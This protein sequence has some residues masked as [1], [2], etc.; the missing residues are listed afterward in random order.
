MTAAGHGRSDKPQGPYTIE[1]FADDLAICSTASAGAPHRLWRV[2]GRQCRHCLCRGL[3]RTR[4]R[5]GLFDTTCWY[6]ADAPAQ[7]AERAQKAID[8]GMKALVGFQKT[9][10][11]SDGFRDQHPDI[12]DRA[13]DVFWPMTCA[14]TRKPAACWARRT[15]AR[16]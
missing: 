13:I 16:R 14:V 10:W 4:R 11:F 12:V 8:E 2:D 6:G 3:S 5:L 15:N 1:L 9:R 7:W